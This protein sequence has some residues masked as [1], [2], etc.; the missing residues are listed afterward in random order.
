MTT[1]SA[2]QTRLARP[3]QP[4]AAQCALQVVVVD[5]RLRLA[6]EH[7]QRVNSRPYRAISFAALRSHL[8]RGQMAE[9]RRSFCRLQHGALPPLSGPLH[10]PGQSVPDTRDVRLWDYGYGFWCVDSCLAAVQDVT[11]H[12]DTRHH[13]D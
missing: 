4:A 13:L 6:E 12:V 10:R 9:E 7:P 3:T 2:M 5:R 8:I 1:A 11:L